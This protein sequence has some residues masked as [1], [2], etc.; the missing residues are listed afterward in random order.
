MNAKQEAIAKVYNGIPVSCT[1]EQYHTD[2]RSTLQEAAGRWIDAGQDARAI[3]ALE[4]VKRLDELYDFP[5]L[6]AV[7]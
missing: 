3:I 2:V 5:V 4:E 7:K 1:K 6:K